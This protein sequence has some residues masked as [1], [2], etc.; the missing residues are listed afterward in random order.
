MDLVLAQGG[1]ATRRQ[2]L[3]LGLS[4][5]Q[6]DYRVSKGEWKPVKRGVYQLA[7]PRDRRDLM[8]AVIAAWERSVLSH[9]T[10]AEIHDIPFVDRGRVVVSHHSRTTHQY[11]DL[12]VHRTHDLDAWHVSEVDRLR[13]TTVARTIV[14]LSATRSV[15]HVGAIVD[16]LVGDGRV[17]LSEIE[18][19][20]GSVARR[21]K[22]GTKVMREVLEARIG[23]DS[24]VSE[25]ESR[26]RNLILRAGL[27]LPVSEFTIPWTTARRF[28][29]A[30]PDHRIAIEWDSRRY[31]GQLAA[32]ESDRSRDR[33]AAV[34]GWRVL[35]FTWDDV[36]NHPS[37]VVDSLRSLL[38]E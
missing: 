18:A 14:D 11:P 15:R 33:D 25:L 10:A 3:D 32:F 17:E 19:V 29:D 6:I 24:S 28:D 9:E 12:E 31:H 2:L 8:R 23:A 34:H 20:L 27:P 7:E 13:V 22:P 35:R 30:Y 4:A 38:A 21:G 37:R 36:H 5:R 26:A 1:V 16:R